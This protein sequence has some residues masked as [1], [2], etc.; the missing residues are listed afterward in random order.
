VLQHDSRAE[1][2]R[3]PK[4]GI[5]VIV[6][7]RWD[8]SERLAGTL[9][10]DGYHVLTI[11]DISAGVKMACCRRTAAIIANGPSN[12]QNGWTQLRRVPSDTLVLL[13]GS[14]SLG[15][16]IQVGRQVVCVERQPSDRRVCAVLDSAW[17]ARDGGR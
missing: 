2:R 3:R 8:R 4:K 10:T 6:D 11:E 15:S 7:D 9:E 13:L 5:V 1:R 16:R 17:A 14:N 12:I